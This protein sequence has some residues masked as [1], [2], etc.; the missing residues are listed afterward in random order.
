MR[1]I[2]SAI[3]GSC[4]GS[5]F[6]RLIVNGEYLAAILTVIAFVVGLYFSHGGD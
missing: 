3:F 1:M 2:L 6:V 5:I 4:M